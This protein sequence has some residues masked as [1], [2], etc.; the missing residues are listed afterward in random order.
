M[1][2]KVVLYLALSS[3]FSVGF[4]CHPC[5]GFWLMQHACATD[6]DNGSNGAG[7]L[8]PLVGRTNTPSLGRLQ[9]TLSYCGSKLGTGSRFRVETPR[10]PRLPLG[11]LGAPAR[12][13]RIAPSS[14]HQSALPRALYQK[15]VRRV[16]RRDGRQFDFACRSKVGRAAQRP[17]VASGAADALTT[18]VTTKTGA[19]RVRYS[20]EEQLHDALS[21][22]TER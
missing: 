1:A 5:I 6:P 3:A 20:A 16:A 17:S 13:G 8:E 19:R 21:N 7:L 14:I 4:L 10:A 2:S 9:P 15:I 11:A 18:P 12:V 22:T